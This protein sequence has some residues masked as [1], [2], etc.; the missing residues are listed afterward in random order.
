MVF[1]DCG[2]LRT[3]V[4]NGRTGNF[5]TSEPYEHY[6]SSIV[7]TI[8]KCIVY[9]IP[10]LFPGVITKLYS[11][12]RVQKF[13]FPTGFSTETRNIFFFVKFTCKRIEVQNG[14][15]KRGKKMK[16]KS[17]EKIFF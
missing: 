14:Q 11:H 7:S 6:S 9:N 3:D 12:S 4:C 16:A 17:R 10:Y 13:V 5:L 15:I 8:V 1:R 2:G